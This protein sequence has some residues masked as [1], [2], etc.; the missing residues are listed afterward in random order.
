MEPS[1][2]AR[3]APPAGKRIQKGWEVSGN[4]KLSLN[5]I[6]IEW[7]KSGEVLVRI[8]AAG[9]CG[10][11]LEQVKESGIAPLNTTSILGMEI[12]GEIIAVGSD[13]G[14]LA[15]GDRVCCLLSGGGFAEF[16]ICPANFCLLIPN[17]YSWQEAAAIPMGI[18]AGDNFLWSASLNFGADYAFEFI[19]LLL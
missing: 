18:T 11:D 9:V 14:L 4:G 13:V 7:P 10:S 15:E 12:S 16:C 3:L 1:S 5:S 19:T 8:K 17:G 6:P 2:L